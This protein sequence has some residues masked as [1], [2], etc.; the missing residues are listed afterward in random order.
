LDPSGV[1]QQT[2]LKAHENLKGFRGK[3][4]A[5]LQGWLRAILAQQLTLIA[6][7]RGQ[8]Q[9]RTHSLEAALEQS[10]ARLE[11]LVVTDETSPSQAMARAER[12]V[13]LAM[14]LATLPEDQR[15]GLELR[16]LEGLSVPAVAEQMGR[17]TVSVTGLLYRGTRALRQQMTNLD[18]AKQ[19]WPAT[20]VRCQGGYSTENGSD[21]S[22]RFLLPTSRPPKPA[23]PLIERSGWP[24]IPILLKTSC[25]SWT[26]RTDCSGSPS[27]YGRSP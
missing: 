23:K 15:S 2:L 3:T 10:L 19:P 13:E 16:Y 1:V 25:G 21:N 8:D 18:E 14:Q 17:S 11:S 12:L 20:R 5:E 26:I 22:L 9:V 27:R 6:R 4:D 7:K 24:G